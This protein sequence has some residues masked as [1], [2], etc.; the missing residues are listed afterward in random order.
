MEEV[1]IHINYFIRE[2]LWGS[3][4]NFCEKV[5]SILAKFAIVGTQQGAGCCA[6]F[7]EGLWHL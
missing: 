6:Y 7:L 3:C 5:S 2:R 1:L 4:R